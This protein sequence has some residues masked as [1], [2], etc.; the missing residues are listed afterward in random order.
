MPDVTLL[1]MGLNVQLAAGERLL[2]A[3]DDAAPGALSVSCR[4]ASCGSCRL[5]VLE[6]ASAFE[7]PMAAEVE[8]LQQLGAAEGERLGCQL[9]C[10]AAP[11]AGPI[12]LRALRH[13]TL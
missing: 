8:T 2:D 10:A 9:R 6:G 11:G 4:A 3:C 13:S 7:P 1:P 5:Q 12:V